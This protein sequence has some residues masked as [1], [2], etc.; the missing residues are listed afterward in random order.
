MTT[1]SKGI[2]PRSLENA[3]AL[4]ERALPV[5]RLSAEAFKE[6][7]AVHGKTLTAL[8]SY[9]KGR[10]PLILNKA[11]VLGCLLPA[12]DEPAADLEIFELLM[13]MDDAS[14]EKRGLRTDQLAL[15]YR[16]RVDAARRPEE[17]PD[18]HDHIWPRVNAHLGTT[19]GSI[20]ELVEQLGVMRFGHRPRV[21]DT[22]AGSGQIPFEAARLGC[23]VYASDLN[24]IA[25]MLTWGSFNIVGGTAASRAALVSAQAA[26]V[27]DVQREIDLLDVET[28]GRGWRAKVYLYC[29]EV[30]CPET[31][32][33][34]PM[35]P[36]LIISKGYRV[37]AKL[38][39][40]PK[41]MRYGIEVVTGATDEEMTAAERGDRAL[42]RSRTRPLPLPHGRGT[43]IP[44]ARLDVAR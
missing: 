7:M 35:L 2:V 6:Q 13:G 10:K 24:P 9:W 21:G 12:T 36:S 33:R 27:R 40:D 17:R 3:P 15:P 1:R 41:A 39:P 20:P 30:T 4:I 32:W 38:V 18:V 34:V 42:R 31:G 14:F 22:F 28:D 44:D 37:V 43:R 16:E 25:C 8:G 11:C 5:Q 23:D 29:L 26:L 19:A